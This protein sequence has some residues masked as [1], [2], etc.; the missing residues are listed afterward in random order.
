[1][2]L[3]QVLSTTLMNPVIFG[4][5]V[6]LPAIKRSQQG[7]SCRQL[8]DTTGYN[9]NHRAGMGDDPVPNSSLLHVTWRHANNPSQTHGGKQ[10]QDEWEEKEVDQACRMH[11][12]KSNLHG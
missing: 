3:K 1:M 10:L 5:P 8:I 11:A 2:S 9:G 12:G 6:L 4:F 7:F